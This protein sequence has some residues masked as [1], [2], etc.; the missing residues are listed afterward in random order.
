M[1]QNPYEILGVS[2]SA[3]M[4]EIKKAY[5]KKAKECHPDLHP[6]DPNANARMQQVNEAYDM[7]CN[8]EKYAARQQTQ[9]NYGSNAGYGRPGGYTGYGRGTY[10]DYGGPYRQ[11]QNRY[12]QYTYTTGAGDQNPWSAW[13]QSASQNR[14]Q[15][16]VSPFRGLF[17][18]VGGLLLF[19]FVMSLLRFGLFGFFF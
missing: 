5:R 9:G 2:R 16:A 18:V 8:P 3:S 17:K 12:W 15:R 1:I 19:R 13:N 14:G 6:D 4:D 11:G 10:G 7:L